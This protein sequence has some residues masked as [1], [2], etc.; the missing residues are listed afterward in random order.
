[1]KWEQY[2]SALVCSSVT[3]HMHH[4][5]GQITHLNVIIVITAFSQDIDSPFVFNFIVWSPPKWTIHLFK[6]VLI[7]KYKETKWMQ[8]WLNTSL[9]LEFYASNQIDQLRQWITI[10]KSTKRYKTVSL[11]SDG[12]NYNG[13]LWMNDNWIK[14]DGISNNW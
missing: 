8:Q 4:V 10:W 3:S 2:E 13:S 5:W 11:T 14:N 9:I 1:M 12:M 7:Y 6:S